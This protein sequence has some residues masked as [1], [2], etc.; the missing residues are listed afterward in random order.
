VDL[1]AGLDD[2][3]KRIFLTL[4]GLEL[5]HMRRLCTDYDV[6]A[7]I[8]RRVSV[9]ISNTKLHKNTSDSQGVIW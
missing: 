4:P 5:R 7:V 3:E 8:S 1:K 2:L 6:T 9:K